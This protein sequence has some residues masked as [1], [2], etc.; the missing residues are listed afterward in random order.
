MTAGE[1]EEPHIGSGPQL[2][3][4]EELLAETYDLL[5]RMASRQLKGRP[6][7]ATLNT[8]LIVHEAWLK[9]SNDEARRYAG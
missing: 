9:L 1:K 2:G 3:L 6:A 7:S 5:R 8:T 4:S